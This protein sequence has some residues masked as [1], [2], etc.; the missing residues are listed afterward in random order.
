MYSYQV[1]FET[2]PYYTFVAADA[3]VFARVTRKAAT[4]HSATTPTPAPPTMSQLVAFVGSVC[5]GGGGGAGGGGVMGGGG[6]ESGV[7]VGGTF[8]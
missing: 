2:D 5:S 8:C 6:G 1:I 3:P 4:P 7:V